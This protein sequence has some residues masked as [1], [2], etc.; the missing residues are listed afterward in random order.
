MPDYSKGVIYMIEP[1]VEYEAGDVY[2]GSTTQPLYKRFHTHKTKNTTSSK[3]LF[4]KYSNNIKIVLVKSFPCN[5]K[6]ELYAEEGK[7]IRENQC[8]NK[9]IEGRSNTEYYQDNKE[10]IKEYYQDNKEKIKAY[11]QEH[12]E[13]TKSYNKEYYQDNKAELI[14]NQKAYYQE[15]KEEKKEY[16]K[17][18]RQNNKEKIKAYGKEWRQEHKEELKQKIKCE[19]GCMISKYTLKAHKLTKKHTQL[20]A[21]V[22]RRE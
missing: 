21:D 7:Y 9:R 1:T 15:H 14:E 11:C 17:A 3:H 20:L 5:S 19:C 10:K 2:Y 18:Y 22:I 8:V 13:E 12:K 6:Q 16:D 4:E